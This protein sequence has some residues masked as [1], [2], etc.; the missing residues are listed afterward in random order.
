MTSNSP[1]QVEE[2]AAQAD[3]PVMAD[4][5]P[6]ATTEAK[7]AAQPETPAS[8]ASSTDAESAEG[9][10]SI[11]KAESIERTESA[12]ST[13]SAEEIGT[14]GPQSVANTPSTEPAG[15]VQGASPD[16]S[17]PAADAEA[18]V[19]TP[20]AGQNPTTA[21]TERKPA[22][23]A[24][25]VA[26]RD[27]LLKLQAEAEQLN[28]K[29]SAR[30]N[31]LRNRLHKLRKAIGEEQSE[32]RELV[33][34]L[35]TR[36]NELMTRNLEHQQALHDK[37]VALVATL[38]QALADGK[39]EQALPTWDKIQGNIS[40][41]SGRLRDALQELT[42]PLKGQLDELRDW[43][44]FAATE[45]KRELV[46]RM[47][48]LVDAKIAPQDLNRQIGKMHKD[49]KAL[50]RSND[51]DK[52]WAEFKKVSDQAYEP[53]KEFFKQRKQLMAD[54][55][56]QRRDLCDKLE[57]QLAEIDRDAVD[58]AA[59]N[60][61]L[62]SSDKAWK[63]YAPVEQSKIKPLQKRYY[64]LL[65]ELRKLRKSH[66]RDNAARKQA[67]IAEAVKLT[68][69]D[70][71]R[72]AMQEAK[73]LQRQWKD[74]GPSSFKEDKN[75]WAEF[76]KACDQIFA[77]RDQ[78][79]AARKQEQQQA[80][81]ELRALLNRL[82]QVLALD[83]AALR[84]AKSDFHELARQFNA[85]LNA[86]GRGARNKLVDRFNDLKRRIDGRFRALP[87]K[88]TQALRDNLEAL[89]V[90]LEPVEQTLL[91][92]A[93]AA[94]SATLDDATWQALV[95]IGER[96]LVARLEARRNALAAPDTLAE[97]ARK[98]ETELRTLC[99]DAEIRAGVDSPESDQGTRMQIQLKQL[100]DGFGQSRPTAKENQ[101]YAQQTGLLARCIGPLDDGTRKQLESRLEQ[102]LRRLN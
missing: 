25:V 32:L 5:G 38:Q 83:D 4:S 70:D 43:K 68:Q 44:I 78:E 99:I 94:Q 100:Q 37:T 23:P 79:S 19:T 72:Q 9:T 67:L 73:R 101:R 17:K 75:Y 11:D 45:K 84:E 6:A 90:Q 52:L 74:I 14:E 8:P 93:S 47:Q 13:E 97:Q 87:D 76:R 56:K 41:T 42:G 66:A 86:Q 102:V 59:I 7:A 61:L 27:T 53:C 91:G 46:G 12:K 98:A 30:L 26:D 31:N 29:H 48:Q 28:H 3:Q 20:S 60:K 18:A 95:N 63:K 55:L 33:A 71:N 81:T 24:P 39:S 69:L 2:A 82:D 22:D 40:N 62:A 54:N 10:E 35:D 64:G 57:A 50:G 88:K 92:E 1:D 58:V 80:E 16:T 21:G 89:L 34:T 36:V 51:N 49:W 15:S 77:Q 96:Q 85:T 65:N